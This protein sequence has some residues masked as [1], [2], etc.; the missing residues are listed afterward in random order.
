MQKRR[1]LLRRAPNPS[2]LARSFGQSSGA[3]GKNVST[4]ARAAPKPRGHG[5]SASMRWSGPRLGRSGQNMQKLVSALSPRE[6]N[7]VDEPC[8]ESP[9]RQQL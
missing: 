3:I 2:N 5:V 8:L 6:P 4:L 7:N 9:E 1:R